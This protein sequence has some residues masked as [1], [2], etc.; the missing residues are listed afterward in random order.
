M[1]ATFDDA[2]LDDEVALAAADPVLRALAEAGARVRREA[3][4]AAEAVDSAVLT[5]LD[6][7]RPRAVVA[8]GTDS[9]LLRAVLEPWCPVPFVAWSGPSLPGWTGPLDLVVVLAPQDG[10]AGTASS[11]AEAVRR[12]CSLVIACPVPSL[13]GDH[14]VGR[15]TTVLPTSTGDQLA[16]AVV[17]LELLARVHLGPATDAA[18]VADALDD[19]AVACSPYRSLSVNPAKMLALA[20]GDTVP[21]LWGSSVLSARA[22]R[23]VAESIRRASGRA[24]LAADAAQLLPVLSAARARDVF[25][26]PLTSEDAELRPGLLIFDDGSDDEVGLAQGA[27]LTRVAEERDLRVETLEAGGGND[28]ARYASLVATGGFTAAYLGVGLGPGSAS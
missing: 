15:H 22:A 24:A 26:D 1:A 23:R 25:A 5:A 11:A 13:V 8:A 12:G 28:V 20:L 16:T 18:A 19:V 4:A 10:D 9:R 21:L 6:D 17:M 7:T 3:V 27:H 2:R 14:A